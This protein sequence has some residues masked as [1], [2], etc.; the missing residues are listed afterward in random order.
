MQADRAELADRIARRCR[1]TGG[2]SR[3]RACT[4]AASVDPHQSGPRR[5]WS[6]RFCVIAQGSKEILLGERRFRYDPAHYLIST[7]GLPMIGEVVEASPRRPYLG[8][9]LALDPA[10]VASVMVESGVVQ[11]RGEGGGV[12]AVD[13]SP[14]DADL[15]DATVRLVRLDRPPRRVPGARAARRSARSSTAC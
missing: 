7:M 9:R 13:V 4:S 10:V 6:R 2:P 3:S 1:A 12:N 11:P 15:L 14:L 5:R 8:F